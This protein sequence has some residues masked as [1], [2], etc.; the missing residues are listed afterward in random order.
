MKVSCAAI[1]PVRQRAAT[2][3]AADARD[4]S[5][6]PVGNPNMKRSAA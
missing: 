4:A 3:P 1:H 2:P 5:G 6:L